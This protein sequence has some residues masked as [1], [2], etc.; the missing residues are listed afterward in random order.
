MNYLFKNRNRFIVAEDIHNQK[1]MTQQRFQ[2]IIPGKGTQEPDLSFF[3]VQLPRTICHSNRCVREQTMRLK[4]PLMGVYRQRMEFL[5]LDHI[6]VIKWE[7]ESKSFSSKNISLRMISGFWNCTTIDQPA[8]AVTWW[9]GPSWHR[10]RLSNSSG[11]MVV[12]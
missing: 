9:N 5:K 10:N 1:S 4:G 12:Q 3:L 6:L 11:M 7:A 2:A 8:I